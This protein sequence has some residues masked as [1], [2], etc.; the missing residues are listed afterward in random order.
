M[1]KCMS[2]ATLHVDLVY[3]VAYLQYDM[4]T[5]LA[6]LVGNE[7]APIYAFGSESIM[8]SMTPR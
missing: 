5:T 6:L 1:F 8:Q 7:N 4:L 3:G 2:P